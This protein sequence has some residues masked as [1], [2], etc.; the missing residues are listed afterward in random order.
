MNRRPVVVITGA[1]AGVGRATAL[2][3]ARRGWNVALIARSKEGLDDIRGKI[4]LGGGAALVI[5]IDVSDSDAMFAAADSVVAT[6]GAI[7]VWVNNAMVT[8]LA[9][10]SQLA[11]EEARRVTEVTYLGTVHGTMA[12]LKH[13]RTRN[14]GAIV[15]V[16][17]AL[18]YRAIP[19]QAAYCAAKYA[20]RGFSDA[21]RS[22]LL[23]DNSNIR[24]TMVQ[25]PAINTPQ[26]DWARNKLGRRQQPLP[27]IFQPETA[28]EAIYRAALER[29]RESWVGL[30]SLKAI[31]GT[32]LAPN[33]LD[34]MMARR[35]YTG[36]LTREP[37]T[38]GRPDN[39]FETVRGL[40]RT[41][42][43]FDAKAP[44]V[45]H[46]YDPKLVRFANA[47]LVAAVI[48]GVAALAARTTLRSQAS[49]PR[50]R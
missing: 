48:A 8:V 36:Q 38:P 44:A 37:E 5:P 32:M 30:S 22:E 34:R 3:F 47:A 18:A 33:L 4:E 40:H 29:R 50:R 15:Q 43:R 14:T 49:G 12:A 42:G 6:W 2:A 13:M 9:P 11:P 7:D 31:L 27:P 10:V 1:S 21:L 39:L 28:A 23:H 45:A 20:V 26:F 19:L 16:G 35:A 46:A 17:S 25:L 24:I 41:R